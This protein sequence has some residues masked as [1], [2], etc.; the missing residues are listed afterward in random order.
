MAK[1]PL[2]PQSFFN[3]DTKEIV[4]LFTEFYNENSHLINLTIFL[5]FLSSSID[6]IIVP[7][8]LDGIFNNI[9]YI[10]LFR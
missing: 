2:K 10:N 1:E 7:R 5:S 8:I 6:T 9:N 4:L 3:S